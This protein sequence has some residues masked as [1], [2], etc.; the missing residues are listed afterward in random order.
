M[1]HEF[2]IT[3]T[4]LEGWDIAPDLTPVTL[5]EDIPLE[6]F[7]PGF[8]FDEMEFTEDDDMTDSEVLDDVLDED[9]GEEATDSDMLENDLIDE[10]EDAANDGAAVIP[11]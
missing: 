1:S 11:S 9:A 10:D 2:P 3:Q 5:P 7:A 6:E 8:P 4:L